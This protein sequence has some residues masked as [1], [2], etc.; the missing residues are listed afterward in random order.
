MDL[1]T[2][3]RKLVNREGYLGPTRLLLLR[4]IDPV[5]WYVRRNE[6]EEQRRPRRRRARG[7]TGWTYAPLGR[8]ATAPIAHTAPQHRV[9]DPA[10]LK[11]YLRKLDELR[12][13]NEVLLQ[14]KAREV[15]S[16]KPTTIDHARKGCRAICR[17]K[18][19]RAEIVE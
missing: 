18:T 17:P 4:L 14:G 7:A 11:T 6:T 15:L 1:R 10:G 13:E 2:R 5:E 12:R 8:E 9:E 16:G 3:L 19:R